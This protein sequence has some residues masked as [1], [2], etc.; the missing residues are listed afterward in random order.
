MKVRREQLISALKLAVDEQEVYEV[1][2]L[3]YHKDSGLLEVWRDILKA[4]ENGESL[5]FMD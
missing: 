5:W 4:V 3:K 1:K 2:K